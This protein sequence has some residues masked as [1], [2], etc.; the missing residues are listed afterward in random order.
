MSH[1]HAN[2]GLGDD[3]TVQT[4]MALSGD[5]EPVAEGG[6]SYLANF[7]KDAEL[8]ATTVIQSWMRGYISRKMF[9]KKM[10]CRDG[11]NLEDLSPHWK[12][13]FGVVLEAVQNDGMALQFASPTLRV[14]KTIVL[15]AVNQ[16]PYA[17]AHAS[18]E[19]KQDPDVIRVVRENGIHVVQLKYLQ[20]TSFG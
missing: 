8:A 18:D 19:L 17:I 15:V 13:C 11:E 4:S 1:G 10:V 20:K 12:N 2:A 5:P 9:K 16:N 14:D 3:T 6:V 7:T